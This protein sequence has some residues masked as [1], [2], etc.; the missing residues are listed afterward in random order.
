MT[1]NPKL[2]LEPHLSPA[3][4]QHRYRAARDASE[5]RRWQALWLFS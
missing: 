2:T 1:K 4:L 3:E 5:A